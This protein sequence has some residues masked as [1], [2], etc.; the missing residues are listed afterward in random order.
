ME[1]QK[2]KMKSWKDIADGCR[3]DLL[4]MEQN[5]AITRAILTEA[6]LHVKNK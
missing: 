1:Q 6:E 2:P 4:L 3:N 5:M